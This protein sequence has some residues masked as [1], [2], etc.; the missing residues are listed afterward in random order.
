M[1][2]S[3]KLKLI[4]ADVAV[5]SIP[6]LNEDNYLNPPV[7]SRRPQAD[8]TNDVKVQYAQMVGLSGEA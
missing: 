2:S 1:A 3:F 6:I 8:C 4:R 5:A 7:V